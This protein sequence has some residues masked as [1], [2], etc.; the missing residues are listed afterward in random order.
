MTEAAHQM[1]SN[2]LEPGKRVPGSVGKGTNVDISIM[3]SEGNMLSNYE[4]GE[5][6]IKGD[7]V[8]NGY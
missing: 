8:I 2:P 5:I 6:V 7:N 1:S 3:D 4:Q